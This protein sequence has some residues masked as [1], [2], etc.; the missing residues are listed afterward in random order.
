MTK[1]KKP[2]QVRTLTGTI[3]TTR[4]GLGF[5][6]H[7]DL[8]EDVRIEQGELNTALNGDAVEVQILARIPNQQPKGR[9]KKIIRRAKTH[10]VGVV[11]REKGLCFL[12]PDDKRMYTD[13]AITEPHDLKNDVKVLVELLEWTDPNKDPIGRVIK[14]IGLKGDHEV[15]IQ[16]ILYE[17]NIVVDFPAEVAEAAKKIEKDWCEGSSKYIEE[18]IL[19]GE[20]RDFRNITTFTIDP[21]TAKDFDDALS[22]IEL[23]NGMYEIGVHIADVSHYVKPGTELDKEAQERAFSSYLVD[24]TIPMLPPELSSDICSLNPNVERL[25]F[26][27]VITVDKDGGTHDHWFGK[28]VMHS[29]KRF[30]YKDAQELLNDNKKDA[31]WF[32]ELYVLNSISK[33]LREQRFK[34]GAID[35]DQDE[36]EV[37]IDEIG[38]AHV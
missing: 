29:D 20:R 24:R 1:N 18:A 36:V 14:T 17:N 5:L 9:V 23:D 22:V 21:E 16:S 10:F 30:T 11:E 7:P 25:T 6:A 28:G 15:E 32:K 13:I 34:E 19:S 31:R 27:A 3:H 33:K 37:E 35:F 4:G 26:S 8:D 12:V 38:R 2:K